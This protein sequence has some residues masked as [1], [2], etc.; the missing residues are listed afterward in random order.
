MITAKYGA[1]ASYLVTICLSHKK[2]L[3]IE[4]CNIMAL[5]LKKTH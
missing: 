1:K 4:H 2:R 5:Q 3:H